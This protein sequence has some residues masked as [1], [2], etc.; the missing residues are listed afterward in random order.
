MAHPRT[1]VPEDLYRMVLAGDPQISP[2]GRSV[3]FVRS[4]VAGEKRELQSHIWIVPRPGAAPR[5]Y[6]RGPHSD[7]QPRW[8]PDGR[9]LAF[10]RRTGEGP[11]A[12]RQIWIIERDGG[13]AYQLTAMRHGATNP[14]WSRDGRFLAF[15]A[16]VDDAYA[17]GAPEGSAKELDP[18]RPK[19]DADRKREEKRR[20]DEAKLYT[21]FRYKSEH[22]GLVCTP[23]QPRMGRAGARSAAGRRCGPRDGRRSRVPSRH[24]RAAHTR[25][26][27]GGPF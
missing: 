5:P 27:D 26:G 1:F 21:R 7:S 13:E 25:P 19:T 3:V 24:G 20:R 23:A 22:G 14:V 6:T 2:D 9:R 11:H 16:A 4:H 8:S 18:V 17:E 12:D 15:I 10:V